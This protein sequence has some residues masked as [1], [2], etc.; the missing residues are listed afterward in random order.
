MTIINKSLWGAL[1]FLN[2]VALNTFAQPTL[3]GGGSTSLIPPP[4][5][6]AIGKCRGT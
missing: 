2:L 3:P 1:I 4:V 5:H 6:P